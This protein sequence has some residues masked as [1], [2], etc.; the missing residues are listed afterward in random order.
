MKKELVALTVILALAAMLLRAWV[1]RPDVTL[2]TTPPPLITPGITTTPPAA[3]I[4][5]PIIVRQKK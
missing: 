4:Y 5:L 1:E 2:T 3:R